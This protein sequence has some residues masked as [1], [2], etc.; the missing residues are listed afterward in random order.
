MRIDPLTFSGNQ[1]IGIISINRGNAFAQIK[2]G[3][4]ESRL[5]GA[6][7]GREPTARVRL[8]AHLP[9]IFEMMR[10]SSDQFANYLFDLYF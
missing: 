7:S 5:L 4:P 8:K 10:P 3:G 9:R 1:V 2:S 6:P